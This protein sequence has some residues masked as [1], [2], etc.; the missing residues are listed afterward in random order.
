MH[1]E[2]IAQFNALM[3]VKRYAPNTRKT[4]VNN[5]SQ[6]LNYFSQRNPLE[7]NH[8]DVFRYIQHKINDQQISFSAQK[9]IVGAI[10]LFYKT[11][12][13][14][15]L[16][17]DY[18]YPDRQ[19]YKLPKV[20]SQQDIKTILDTL[21]NIKHKAIIMTIYAC[22]LRLHELIDL[23]LTDIDCNRMTIRIKNSKGNRDREVMLSEKL[24]TLIHQYRLSYQPKKYLFEGQ[25]GGKYHPR[26]VQE[27]FS[28]TLKK[29]KI[30]KPASVH[31]LRHSFATHLIEQGT[32]IRIVQELLGHKNIKTTQIYTHITDLTKLKIKSPLDGI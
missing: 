19:E 7:I 3:E 21:E 30:L 29:A 13:H 12:Y 28:K 26:S 10:K 23:E 17:I 27:L 32:D 15:N 4:Y 16:Q 8:K 2:L 14:K 22:G 11:L 6:F 1:N 31:T 5:I 20:L 9:G 18:I 24:K 25:A